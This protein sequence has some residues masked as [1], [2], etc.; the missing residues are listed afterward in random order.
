M[1]LDETLESASCL[2]LHAGEVLHQLQ[3]RG[4]QAA[5]FRFSVYPAKEPVRRAAR[6]YMDA[7]GA[8]CQ[9]QVNNAPDGAVDSDEFA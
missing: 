2:R 4:L 7:E 5:G 6:K 3:G 9:Q 1:W 8:A